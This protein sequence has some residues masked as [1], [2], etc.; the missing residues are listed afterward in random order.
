MAVQLG[1]RVGCL[2]PGGPRFESPPRNKYLVALQT[3]LGRCQNIIR[4]YAPNHAWYGLSRFA[5]S[6]S[7]R[8]NGPTDF[9]ITGRY[10]GQWKLLCPLMTTQVC[11]HFYS[12]DLCTHFT[13]KYSENVFYANIFRKNVLIMAKVRFDGACGVCGVCVASAL[14]I[15]KESATEKCSSKCFS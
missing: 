3:Y 6:L 1:G 14:N 10:N 13:A 8:Y 15:C 11:P 5:R 9:S 2:A 4:R 12:C 7:G